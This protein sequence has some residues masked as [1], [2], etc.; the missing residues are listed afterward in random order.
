LVAKNTVGEGAG[1]V[2]R[3]SPAVISNDLLIRSDSILYRLK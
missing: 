3:S 2:F 1:E